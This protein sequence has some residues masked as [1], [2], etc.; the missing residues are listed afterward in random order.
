MSQEL[1]KHSSTHDSQQPRPK[2]KYAKLTPKIKQLFLHQ[3]VF[4]NLSIKEAS[5]NLRINYSSAK[6]IASEHKK[7]QICH[8]RRGTAKKTAKLCAY[9]ALPEGHSHLTVH[10]ICS[11]IGGLLVSDHHSDSSNFAKSY[12]SFPTL[13]LLTVTSTCPELLQSC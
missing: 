4:Q 11:S 6:A 7:V 5:E 2:K 3:I 9:L 10:Q 13:P 8:S 12:P 1:E